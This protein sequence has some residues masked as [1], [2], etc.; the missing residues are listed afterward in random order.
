GRAIQGDIQEVALREEDGAEV[1]FL[2]ELWDWGGLDHPY[3]GCRRP[4]TTFPPL[5]C[6]LL[7]TPYPLHNSTQIIAYKNAKYHKNVS[8]I[9][10]FYQEQH[11]NWHVIDGF[12][13]KWWVW[14]EVVKDIQQMNKYIQIY[15]EKIKEGKAACIDKLCI[16]PE[17]LISRLG[18]FGQFCPVSLA[19]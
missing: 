17:E 8:E 18:E 6:F 14:N 13:S 2:R 4:S 1:I 9:R 3:R 5:P 10:Q 19:E 15:M 12:H 16:T 11:Q 7:S